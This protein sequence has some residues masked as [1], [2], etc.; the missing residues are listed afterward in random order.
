MSFSH[1]T[2]AGIGE[3]APSSRTVPDFF[4]RLKGMLFAPRTEWRRVARESTTRW[5][6]FYGYFLPLATLT[7]LLVPTRFSLFTH[8]PLAGVAT[9]VAFTLAFQMLCVY[10]VSL[11][12][13]GVA[14]YFRGVANPGQSFK[15]AAYATTP[16]CLSSLSFPFPGV[17]VPLQLVAGLYHIFL[18]YLGVKELMKSPRDR[19]LGYATTVVLSSMILGIVYVQLSAALGEALRLGHYTP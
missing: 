9:L 19:A 15:V 16:L 13:S 7:A 5:Q 6:L 10:V 12:I 1:E 8:A 3:T 11:I 17:F 4:G 2:S 14:L 18:M